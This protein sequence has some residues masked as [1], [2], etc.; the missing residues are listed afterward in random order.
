MGEPHLKADGVT[1]I[2]PP[3]HGPRAE[4]L[5]DLVERAYYFLRRH[6]AEPGSAEDG[7]RREL[8]AHMDAT[9]G[10]VI[11]FPARPP[12][13]AWTPLE[14]RVA[15]LVERLDDGEGAPWADLVVAAAMDRIDER[16]VESAVDGL[17]D[18]GAVYEP[19]LGRLKRT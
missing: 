5:L 9:L 11:G 12:S 8:L 1:N 16:E 19:I 10:E 3:A 14:Q 15:A 13:R 7:E 6:P 2:L 17:I 18:G 4:R